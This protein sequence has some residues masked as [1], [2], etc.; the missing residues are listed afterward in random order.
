[1]RHQLTWT[2]DTGITSV[3]L[4]VQLKVLYCILSGKENTHN[5]LYTRHKMTSFWVHCVT[6]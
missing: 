4:D 3:L 2:L 1:M 6:K 5:T